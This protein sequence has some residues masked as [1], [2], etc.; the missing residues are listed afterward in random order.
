MNRFSVGDRRHNILLMSRSK[1]HGVANETV[2][3]VIPPLASNR[4]MRAGL[5]DSPVANQL[6]LYALLPLHAAVRRSGPL[7]RT[8]HQAFGL[9]HFVVTTHQAVNS[10]RGG[11]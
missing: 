3:R 11:P 4:P 7:C 5:K 9:L 8:V 1:P 10:F 6:A 2:V